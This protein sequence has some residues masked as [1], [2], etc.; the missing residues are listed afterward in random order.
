[1]TQVALPMSGL[2]CRGRVA[3]EDGDEGGDEERFRDMS[4]ADE[5]SRRPSGL[6]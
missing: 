6:R 2:A 3:G 5:S 1:M 4:D